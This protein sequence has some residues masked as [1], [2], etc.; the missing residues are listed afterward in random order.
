MNTMRPSSLERH[1]LQGPVLWGL[2]L[3]YEM[4]AELHTARELAEQVLSLAER[5]QDPA[6]LIEARYLLG[7]VLLFL[8]EPAP[9]RERRRA[10]RRVRA[11]RSS[12]RS[13]SR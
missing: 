9:G 7:E 5:V 1:S 11:R 3:V 12:P 6:L 8:G 10:A 4:R 13:P 2:A